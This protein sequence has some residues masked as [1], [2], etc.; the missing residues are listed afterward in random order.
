MDN[1]NVNVDKEKET[2]RKCTTHFDE[3]S[4]YKSW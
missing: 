1:Q 2:Y 3:Q 4:K